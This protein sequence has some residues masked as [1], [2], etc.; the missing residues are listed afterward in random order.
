VSSAGVFVLLLT[1]LGDYI[2]AEIPPPATWGE[3]RAVE[4]PMT[5][6]E[7]ATSYRCLGLPLPP[8]GS[9]LVRVKKKYVTSF[10]GNPK[11]SE[12]EYEELGWL[13]RPRTA[14]SPAVIWTNGE[15]SREW[16]SSAITP[17]RTAE[18]VR[19][20]DP[21]WQWERLLWAAQ[22]HV[23]GRSEIARA[24]FDSAVRLESTDGKLDPEI[25]RLMRSGLHVATWFA[26]LRAWSNPTD[27]R[28]A[29]A[30]LSEIAST[31]P[32]YRSTE[33]P[34]LMRGMELAVQPS[35]ATPGSIPAL[36]DQFVDVLDN[37]DGSNGRVDDSVSLRIA[38]KGFDAIPDLLKHLTD[39]RVTNVGV[40]SFGCGPSTVYFTTVGNLCQALLVELSN[41]E[42]ESEADVV[43]FAKGIEKWLADARR[44][45]EEEWVIQQTVTPG[46]GPSDVLLRLI[47]AK[48]PHHLPA[49]YRAQLNDSS[50]GRGVSAA[51]ELAR[52]RVDRETKLSLLRR[53]TG[54]DNFDHR[55]AAIAALAGVDSDLA[56]AA[57]GDTVTWLRTRAGGARQNPEAEIDE[58]VSFALRF[59]GP[60]TTRSVAE[61]LG[62]QTVTRRV[63]LLVVIAYNYSF[64]DRNQF[65]LS[66]RLF[67][68][69]L[70]DESVYTATPN[71]NQMG[72]RAV[73]PS[74][75]VRNFATLTMAPLFDIDVPWNPDRTPAEWAALRAKVKAAVEKELAGNK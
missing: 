50:N 28:R 43:A 10:P 45:G 23:R 60:D 56:R 49:I 25:N 11:L 48:Y 6:D 67:A 65:I 1:S 16:L 19:G 29:F 75:E 31:D 42:V 71:A 3:R 13:V 66:T 30:R 68:A 54:H 9:T 44:R 22:I 51:G 52:S 40:G 7:F 33:P 61:L 35:S 17:V 24:L 20:L 41:G 63:D 73:H 59:D 74:I 55:L 15:L 70:S 72:F 37:P 39:R 69:M 8:P 64:S 57:V 12:N 5:L 36:I 34:D 58:F 14:T 26:N 2:S 38:E 46:K 47:R 53:G 18:D 32:N 27:R 21:T 4:R 62:H